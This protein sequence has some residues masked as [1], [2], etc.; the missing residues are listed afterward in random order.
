VQQTGGKVTLW[1]AGSRRGAIDGQWA[2]CVLELHGAGGRGHRATERA[3]VVSNGCDRTHGE[4]GCVGEA[5]PATAA[6]SGDFGLEGT[7]RVLVDQV[8]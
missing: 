5:L 8:Q 6:G 1:K 2:E 7:G 3:R 4:Q